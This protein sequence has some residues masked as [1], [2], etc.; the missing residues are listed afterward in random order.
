MKPNLNDE[1]RATLAAVADVLIPQTE[2]M[3]AASE[4]QLHGRWIDKALAAR[5]D[6]ADTLRKFLD[7]AAGVDPANA[8]T[9]F[10]KEAPAEFEDVLLLVTCSYYMNPKVRKR[11]RYPG[12]KANPP[13]PDEADYYLRDGLLDPVIDRGPIYVAAP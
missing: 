2:T 3:P 1:Q 12:Q 9:T 7:D 6:L 10:V 11:L 5:P 4:V 8:V 13:Y